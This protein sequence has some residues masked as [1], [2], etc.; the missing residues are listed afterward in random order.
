M[1]Q[2]VLAAS[3]SEEQSIWC[4]QK[5]IYSQ[6]PDSFTVQGD[7]LPKIYAPF[8]IIGISQSLS[9]TNTKESSETT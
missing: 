7:W 8:N 5:L 4:C 3:G 9:S 2:T 6:F 1:A